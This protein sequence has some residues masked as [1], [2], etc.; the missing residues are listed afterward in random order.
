MFEKLL[1][2]YNNAIPS[3]LSMLPGNSAR[4]GARFKLGP[5][6]KRAGYMEFTR[7]K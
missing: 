5:K 6:V 2:I 1:Q 3:G 4:E 7:T